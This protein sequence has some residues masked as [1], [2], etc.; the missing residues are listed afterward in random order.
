MHIP[1]QKGGEE[2]CEPWKVD[3]H[4]HLMPPT[5]PMSISSRGHGEGMN[6]LLLLPLTGEDM[7]TELP[8]ASKHMLPQCLLC[9]SVMI[10]GVILPTDD[11]PRR[12]K[13]ATRASFWVQ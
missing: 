10:H 1:P 9:E 8:R 3:Y 6:Q 5:K 11:S 13:S 4:L 12:P 7:D 2:F